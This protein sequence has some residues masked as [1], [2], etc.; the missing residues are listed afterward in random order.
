M[1]V[2]AKWKAVLLLVSL[3][4]IVVAHVAYA[5]SWPSWTLRC[6]IGASWATMLLL[7]W[8]IWLG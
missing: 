8:R 7:A 1:A 4:L 3:A 2:N 6:A 5:F